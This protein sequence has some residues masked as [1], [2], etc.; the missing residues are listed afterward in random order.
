MFLGDMTIGAPVLDAQGRPIAAVHVM[1]PTS[2]WTLADAE[3]RLA[4]AVIEC[5]RAVSNSARA[6]G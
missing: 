4:P 5:A 1:A 3:Q 2:R 6:L